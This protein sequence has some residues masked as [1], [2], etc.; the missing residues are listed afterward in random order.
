MT[1]LDLDDVNLDR[2][3]LRLAELFDVA[4]SRVLHAFSVLGV[5]DHIPDAGTGLDALATA[6]DTDPGRLARLVRAAEC[7]DVVRVDADRTVRLTPAGTLLRSGQPGGLRAE[8][9]DNSLFTAWGPFADC[10]R[11][12]RPSYELVHGTAIF[13]AIGDDPEALATFHE[14][15]RTRAARLYRPLLPFLL[16]RCAPDVVDV[17][18]GTGGLARLLLEHGTT[19]HVTLTDLPE[20]IALVP[21]ELARRHPG[22]FATVAADMREHI[23]PGHGTYV[24]GSVLHDWPDA[25]AGRLLTRCARAMGPG[26]EVILLERV[27]SETGPDPRTMGDMWMMAMTGGQERT[28][29]QWAAL[30]SGAGLSLREVHDAGGE[31]SA[32]VLA[33]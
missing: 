13:D 16:D 29:A 2:E 28:R 4:P 33:H 18:G 17:A 1:D 12:G 27:L 11:G 31:L 14:H 6:L 10:V 21:D 9:S 25:E 7:L 26:S 5:A 20:V 22:R 8:F 24:L 32:V 19:H 30:A 3:R 15:M 23:P